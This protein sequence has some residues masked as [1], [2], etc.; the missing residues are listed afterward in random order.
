MSAAASDKGEHR[1]VARAAQVIRALA[2]A[3]DFGMRLTDVAEATGFGCA[4]VH[5]LLGGLTLHGFVDHD[6]QTN[7]YFIGLQMVGWAAAAT[8][9]YGL[10]PF[11][12]ESLDRLCTETEDTV[13]F[14][15]ISGLD[16]V[17][18]DRRE[19][20]YPVKTL[21]L[22]IGNRRPLGVGAGSLAL[23]A[24]QPEAVRGTIIETD[25]ERRAEYGIHDDILIDAVARC[26]E[27][28][29]A[30]NSG[31]VIPG[32]SGVAVPIRRSDDRAIAALSIVAV[33]PRLSHSRLDGVVGWLKAEASVIETLAA[34]ILDTPL[35]RRT[36]SR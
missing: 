20:V 31:G 25:R 26:R 28:G 27:S 2:G 32:M 22:D 34:K 18:V 3:R 16:A 24:F 33:T 35:A 12:D 7:R 10:A 9:R 4:T 15:L 19:G 14:S 36:A 17:C 8:E 29:F 1:N 6:R 13:Y 23:L 5:R 30:L 11:A 21:T